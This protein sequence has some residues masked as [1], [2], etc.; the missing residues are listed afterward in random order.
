[1]CVPMPENLQ[2]YFLSMMPEPRWM[3]EEDSLGD[4]SAEGK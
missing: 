2:E 4:Y 3:R 1:M